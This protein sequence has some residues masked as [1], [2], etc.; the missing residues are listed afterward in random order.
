MS[1]L[2]TLMIFAAAVLLLL[3]VLALWQSLRAAFGA[4][5]LARFETVGGSVERQVLRDEKAALLR[6]LHDLKFEKQIG[7][8]S[9]EDFV[10]L[11]RSLRARLRTVMRLL[12]ADVAPFRRQ[13]EDLVKERLGELRSAAPY[14]DESSKKRSKTDAVKPVTVEAV[15]V[16]DGALNAG[17]VN[18]GAVDDG[19][20][21][22]CPSCDAKNDPDADWCKKCGARVAPRT[23]PECG[24]TNDAD[25]AFCKHCAQPFEAKAI[26]VKASRVAESSETASSEAA[27][28]EA[29]APK[30]VEQAEGDE[31]LDA[32]DDQ[33]GKA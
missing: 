29:A 1:L 15:S 10:P 25:A 21:R 24:T 13:A 2:A 6:G 19:P 33:G 17:A 3:A 5:S 31:E 32:S 18:A 16:D 27:S 20:R 28:S 14:R 22:V 23:C 8:I 4:V 11:D 9:E 12:D 26:E 30:K 7:K